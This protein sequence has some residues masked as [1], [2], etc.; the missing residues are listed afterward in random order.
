MRLHLNTDSN[1]EFV[2]F[3]YQPKLVGVLHKWIGP[4]DLHG[5]PA[6]Y[7][8]SWLTKAEAGKS[9]LSYPS[10][11]KIFISFHDDEYLKRVVKTILK[12]PGMCF[13]MK[14]VDITIEENPDLSQR[15]AFQCAS[16]IFIHRNDG[17]KDTH[18]TFEDPEAG[19]L[20]EETLRHKMK[21]AGLP[22]DESLKIRFDASTHGARIKIVDYRGIKNRVSICP[23]I[24]EG[25]PETKVFA[26]NVGLGNSTG[27]GFGS[28]Y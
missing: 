27:I 2:S 6:L 1:K 16:P 15:S 24:M 9:G 7:S 12:D 25:K 18:Y 19:S 26:W 8:F 17:R 20:L 22:E 11:A 3:N 5:N 23:V 28:I 10:G 14:V 13:G 4:N 21:L